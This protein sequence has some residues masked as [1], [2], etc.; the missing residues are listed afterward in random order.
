MLSDQP[1]RDMGSPCPHRAA[2]GGACGHLP[3]SSSP[4]TDGEMAPEFGHDI[5]AC[6]VRRVRPV[7]LIMYERICEEALNSFHACLTRP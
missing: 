6:S 3:P 1:L 4:P 2:D 5:L 7:A